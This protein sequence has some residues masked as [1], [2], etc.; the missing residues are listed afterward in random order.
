MLRA[1]ERFVQYVG[2][3]G[4]ATV[5]GLWAVEFAAPRT[6]GWAVGAAVAI[7]GAAVLSWG[8]YVELEVDR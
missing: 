1:M 5:A 8:I 4:L 6:A 3:G 2:G 7:A